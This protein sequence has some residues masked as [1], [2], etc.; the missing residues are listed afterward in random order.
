MAHRRT[1]RGYIRRLIM[2]DAYFDDLQAE[3]T[4]RTNVDMYIP[5][6]EAEFEGGVDMKDL[7]IERGEVLVDSRGRG[8]F[9]Q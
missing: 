8:T 1:P 2:V 4:C 6:L 7:D 5:Q 3:I 9:Q